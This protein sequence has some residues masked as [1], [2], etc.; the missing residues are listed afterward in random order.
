MSLQLLITLNEQQAI[1]PI[2]TNS[3]NRFNQIMLETQANDLQE[4]LGFRL[5]NDL[6]R[7]RTTY[8]Y[9]RLL[10]GTDWDYCGQTIHMSGLKYV[11]AH[12]FFSNYT[13]ENG[14]NDTFSGHITHNWN[15]GERVSDNHRREIEKRAREIAF[16]YWNEVKL[17][18]DNNSST[19]KYWCYS[20]KGQVFKPKMKR[21]S[22]PVTN[23][24]R[25]YRIDRPII[26]ET[27]EIEE[28]MNYENIIKTLTAGVNN[29]TNPFIFP[30]I[31][32]ALTVKDSQGV[33]VGVSW[34]INQADGSYWIDTGIEITDAQIY[35]EGV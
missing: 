28:A 10:N 13:R 17:Y 11:L 32:R 33:N 2:S 1:K 7:N 27:T 20:T 6:V 9:L 15:E 22:R 35:I 23:T 34:G 18:L 12:Y 31:P 3:E 14:V 26:T 19:Y 16:K 21:L 29:F 24:E 8:K 4:L 30:V 5:Y 25:K